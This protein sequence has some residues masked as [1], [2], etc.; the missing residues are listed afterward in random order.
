MPI[1]NGATSGG[2]SIVM[3][4]QYNAGSR[5]LVVSGQLGGGSAVTP[6][7]SSNLAEAA[8]DSVT[9]FLNQYESDCFSKRSRF[10]LLDLY[11]RALRE[12]TVVVV[13]S[14]TPVAQYEPNGQRLVLSKDPR[15][16]SGGKRDAMDEP[17]WHELTHRIEDAHGDIGVFDSALYAERNVDYMTHVIRNGFFTLHRMEQ[18]AKS[19]GS[20]E[21]LQKYWKKF[22]SDIQQAER[23]SSTREYPPDL[24][25][26]EKST[27]FSASL[28]KI[29]DLYASGDSGDALRA[30]VRGDEGST[31]SDPSADSG[32]VGLNTDKSRYK[33][34]DSITVCLTVPGPSRVIVT[35]I[36]SDGA[37]D[38]IIKVED[39][40]RGGC[41]TGKISPPGG[42]ETLILEVFTKDGKKRIG[43]A[44][45]SLEVLQ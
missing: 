28:S 32:A 36:T 7:A 24:A 3:D 43:S 26:L 39:D 38:V 19:G 22:A 17:I 25:E 37:P 23:L 45:T 30:A 27:G 20:R 2:F 13:S 10:G 9:R 21:E 42:P 11:A 33:I 40:G 5:G 34:G 1:P 8:R 29:K 41:K 44:S 6:P 18:L 31:T 15:T 12:V 16:L 4:G 14:L 35:D